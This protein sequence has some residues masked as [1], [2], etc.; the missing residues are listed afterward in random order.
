MM[1][2]SMIMPMTDNC[3]SY[4]HNDN[5]IIKNVL[6]CDVKKM[7]YWIN[8]LEANPSKFRSGLLK[9]K[10]HNAE[11]FNIIVTTIL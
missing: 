5:D 4:A 2:L 1:L 8:S 9:N 6:E 10:S 3:V 7:L 11:D